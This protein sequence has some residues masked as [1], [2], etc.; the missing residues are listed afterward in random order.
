MSRCAAGVLCVYVCLQCLGCAG[1]LCVCLRVG[2]VYGSAVCVGSVRVFV[3]LCACDCLSV[4]CVCV[5]VS[6]SVVCICLCLCVCRV[7]MRLCV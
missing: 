2:S 5:S 3:C 6:A 4:L 7:C 1:V